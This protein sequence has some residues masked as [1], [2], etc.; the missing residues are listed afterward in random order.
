M[1][2]TSETNTRNIVYKVEKSQK[3]DKKIL[4]LIREKT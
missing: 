2:E 3:K 4:T 1:D